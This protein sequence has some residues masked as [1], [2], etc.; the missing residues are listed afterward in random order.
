MKNK[1]LPVPPALIKAIYNDDFSISH[2]TDSIYYQR[3]FNI[4]RQV[5]IL[6]HLSLCTLNT[7]YNFPA[8][9]RCIPS[10]AAYILYDQNSCGLL[11]S[12]THLYKD[13]YIVSNFIHFLRSLI[14]SS[15][16]N[17]RPLKNIRHLITLP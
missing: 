5:L 3:K 1:F 6:Y 13:L 2:F 16:F 7:I 17:F 4:G 14:F 10:N 11:N 8:C 9:A 12:R 15:N